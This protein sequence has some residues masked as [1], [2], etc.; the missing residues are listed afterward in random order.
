MA[1]S[2]KTSG[3]Q[4]CTI[5]TEHSLATVTDP[6]VYQVAV[7]V[8]ALVNAA[9]PDLLELRVYGKARSTD[10]ERLLDRHSLVGAQPSALWMSKP[11]VSPHH[12]RVTV[13]QTQGTGR[14]L[15]WAIYTT[16]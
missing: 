9:T 8:A 10:T 6:G 16:G 5:N 13:R 11:Y 14:T 7:D 1:V 2:V 3:S 15:P 12:F 4:T